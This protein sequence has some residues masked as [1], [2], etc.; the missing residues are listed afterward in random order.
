[1]TIRLRNRITLGFNIAAIVIFVLEILFTGYSLITSKLVF[2]EV[3]Q[4]SLSYSFLFSYNPYYVLASIFIIMLYVCV[5]S[6]I[7]LRSFSKT[8]TTDAVFF[9]LFLM[10]CIFDSAR[11]LIPIINVSETYSKTVIKLGNATLFARLLAPLGLFGATILNEDEMRQK[12]ERNCLIII[13]ASWFFSNFIPL[14]T[15]VILPNFCISYG[16][17]KTIR[18]LSFIIC[19][20]S[21][22]TMF[23]KC[24]KN[25]YKQTRTIGFA[26][27]C[28]GYSTLFSASSM[29]NFLLGFVT[30]TAGSIM[31][32][33]ELHKHYMWL[34]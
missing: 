9:L 16:Y 13:I 26:L 2:P 28:I 20:L 6:H 31:Y 18:Y 24:Y 11:F 3:H 7:L 10:A 23:L 4:K 1:M 15:A 25:E 27:I 22:I 8:Q 5:T 17:F 14:N 30:L 33:L 29:F 32:L 34:D 21:I 12:T 19:F